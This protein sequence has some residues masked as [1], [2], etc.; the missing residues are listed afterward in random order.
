MSL[1]RAW[2]TL[3]PDPNGN[4]FLIEHNCDGGVGFTCRDEVDEKTAR[5]ITL[6][7]EEGQRRRSREIFDLLARS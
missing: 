6:A 7:L 1:H 2:F 5:L 3:F 4:T